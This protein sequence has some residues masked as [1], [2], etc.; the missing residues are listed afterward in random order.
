MGIGIVSTIKG[1]Y[2]NQS[3]IIKFKIGDT[4]Y[5]DGLNITGKI[6]RV[7]PDLGDDYVDLIVVGTNG[8]PIKLERVNYRLVKKIN[9]LE[10]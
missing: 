10:K 9:T 7:I 5:V 6:N 2:S 8:A 1:Y 3:P 4:V